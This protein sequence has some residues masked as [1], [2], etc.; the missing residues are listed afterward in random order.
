MSERKRIKL[1]GLQ[2]LAWLW[3][4]SLGAALSY[5]PPVIAPVHA[6]PLRLAA[7]CRV[8]RVGFVEDRTDGMSVIGRWHFD[9]TRTGAS[10]PDAGYTVDELRVIMKAAEL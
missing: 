9:C 2:F 1:S 4:F 5:R 3:C 6:P 8:K 7:K 10:A